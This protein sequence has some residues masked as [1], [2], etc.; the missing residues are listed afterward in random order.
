[1]HEP[2]SSITNHH[3]GR[4]FSNTVVAPQIRGYRENVH[5]FLTPWEYLDI[6]TSKRR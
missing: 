5:Y 1:M 6:D 2:A 3:D 4:G